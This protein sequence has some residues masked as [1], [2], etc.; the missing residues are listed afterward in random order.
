MAYQ[1]L[2]RFSCAA[3]AVAA[4]SSPGAAPA[5]DLDYPPD[6][7]GEPAPTRVYREERIEEIPPLTE[8]LD[9]PRFSAGPRL[10]PPPAEACRTIVKRRIDEDG[11]EVERSIRICDE[12][13]TDGPAPGPRFRPSLYGPPHPVPPGDI[14]GGRWSGPRW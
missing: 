13:L 5:A 12:R 9:V 2:K 3:L 8:P 7:A 14:P 6:P 1:V 4:L 11:V 10:V